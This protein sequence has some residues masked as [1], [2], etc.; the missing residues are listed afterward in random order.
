MGCVSRSGNTLHPPPGLLTVYT[1]CVSPRAPTQAPVLLSAAW[2]PPRHSYGQGQ[3]P[4]SA[5]EL[6]HY[7]PAT[8]LYNPRWSASSG[9]HPIP[10]NTQNSH[11]YLQKE[12][13][14]AENLSGVDG[15]YLAPRGVNL[16]SRFRGQGLDLGYRF[17]RDRGRCPLPRRTRKSEELQAKRMLP[18][19]HRGTECRGGGTLAPSLFYYQLPSSCL[20]PPG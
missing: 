8:L 13:L 2:L 19:Q 15:G 7:R 3:Q 10:H 11:T 18:P 17:E 9:P 5:R 14:R 4:T 12:R 16:D 20:Q 6:N 1:M